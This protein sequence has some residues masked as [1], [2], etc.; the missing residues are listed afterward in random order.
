MILIVKNKRDQ[1]PHASNNRGPDLKDVLITSFLN[2]V[3]VFGD[4]GY[5]F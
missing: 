4:L 1:D 5:T 3:K 2:D